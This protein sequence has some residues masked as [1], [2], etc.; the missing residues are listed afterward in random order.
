MDFNLRNVEII[1]KQRCQHCNYYSEKNE[2]SQCILDKR[3]DCSNRFF[4]ED[5]R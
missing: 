4:K 1:N 3:F 5:K 2:K